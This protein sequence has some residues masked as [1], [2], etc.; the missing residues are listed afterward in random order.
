MTRK[1]DSVAAAAE[2]GEFAF[3]RLPDI[4]E[5]FI[6]LFSHQTSKTE[7]EEK[8]KAFFPSNKS[9]AS[10]AAPGPG[11]ASAAALSPAAAATAP[12]VNLTSAHILSSAK[13]TIQQEKNIAAMPPGWG[14][15]Q[16]FPD[17]KELE[18]LSEAQRDRADLRVDG[19]R[20]GY[21]DA[22]RRR[23]VVRPKVP[24]PQVEKGKFEIST[25]T[26]LVLRSYGVCGLD[27]GTP[28]TN[29]KRLIVSWSDTPVR[30]YGGA[31]VANAKNICG[32]F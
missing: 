27:R 18:R 3:K 28:V 7:M 19:S 25:G 4:P 16:N 8:L 17:Q 2:A 14:R 5:S 29:K 30:I 32:H 15:P 21:S 12:D 1:F 24:E 26:E 6:Q 23:F 20:H 10:T 31:M 9:E 13:D 22:N 11:P